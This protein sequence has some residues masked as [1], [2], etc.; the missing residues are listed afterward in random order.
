MVELLREHQL[1]QGKASEILAISRYD[2]SDLM[3]H[4]RLPVIDLTLEELE[5]EQKRPLPRS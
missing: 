2:L 1:S 3:K 4:Y 5:A